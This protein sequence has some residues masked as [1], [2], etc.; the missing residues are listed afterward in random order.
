MDNFSRI[1]LGLYPLPLAARIICEP[2]PKVRRWARE[3]SSVV[4]RSLPEQENT[5][6]FLEL[7]ELKFIAMF[8]NEGVSLQV[9][10]RASKLAS[11]QFDTKY[12]FAVR[13]FDTDGKTI[14]RNAYLRRKQ[15]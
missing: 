4:T 1:G 15:R 2:L 6:T 7:M 14:F 13:R 10:K 5:L 11:R 9:I 3:S 8:R 12:P